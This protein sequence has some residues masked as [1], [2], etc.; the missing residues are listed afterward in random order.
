MQAGQMKDKLQSQSQYYFEK[1]RN[2][3]CLLLTAAHP[4]LD[5]PL[6]TTDPSVAAPRLV[7]RLESA[8]K[9]LQGPVDIPA[10]THSN[11]REL[12]LLEA[13]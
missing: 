4:S 1:R 13:L 11:K 6:P 7:I 5:H 3:S 12:V 2:L 10:E 9:A 8:A